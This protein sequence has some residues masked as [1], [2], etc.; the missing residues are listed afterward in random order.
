MRRSSALPRYSVHIK[1]KQERMEFLRCYNKHIWHEET[2]SQRANC[3]ITLT[4]PS[5]HTNVFIIIIINK[6]RNSSSPVLIT[7]DRNEILI[8]FL[9]M[10]YNAC[11]HTST[12][13][14]MNASSMPPS[15]ETAVLLFPLREPPLWL[16]LLVLPNVDGTIRS[17]YYGEEPGHFK[18]INRLSILIYQYR[19]INFSVGWT[20]VRRCSSWACEL[21]T[22]LSHEPIIK[23]ELRKM[24][25]VVAFILSFLHWNLGRF[26]SIRK[27]PNPSRLLWPFFVASFCTFTVSVSYIPSWQVQEC[28]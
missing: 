23:N 28:F 13:M 20:N 7:L 16:L 10:F 9:H 24:Y 17:Q 15:K 14:E 26:F 19:L 22:D 2:R 1:F 12:V 25:S 11:I 5:S 6:N 8:F 18:V 21:D 4:Y 27:F 3:D